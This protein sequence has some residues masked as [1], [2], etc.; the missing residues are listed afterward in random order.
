MFNKR[1]IQELESEIKRLNTPRVTTT[2]QVEYMKGDELGV[3]RVNAEHFH[4]WDDK[5]GRFYKDDKFFAYFGNVVSVIK[6]D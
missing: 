1:R 5:S 3:E 4:M 2:Y 6:V